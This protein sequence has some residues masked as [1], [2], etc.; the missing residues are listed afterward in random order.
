MSDPVSNDKAQAAMRERSSANLNTSGK[1]GVMV[2]SPQQAKNA[3][4]T[5]IGHINPGTGK[6]P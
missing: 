1:E 6:K 5:P 3:P 4:K 2:C